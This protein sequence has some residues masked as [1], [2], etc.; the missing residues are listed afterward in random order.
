MSGMLTT[1]VLD[2]MHG[3][4][5]ADLEI[6]LWHLIQPDNERELLLTVRTNSQGRTDMPLLQGEA[7]R[8]GYY[9]LTFAVGEYFAARKV[10]LPEL[11]FLDT[12]PVRFCIARAS[13]HY[14]V[15][16]LMSPWAYSTYRGS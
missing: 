6:Q 8:A 13:E 10:P 3:I 14:H 12:V 2:T 7:M 4:P 16:L 5:A 1:H 15:P 9:E 11:P